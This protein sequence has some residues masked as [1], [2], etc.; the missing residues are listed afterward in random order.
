MMGFDNCAS[1]SLGEDFDQTISD[2]DSNEW[3]YMDRLDESTGSE[4]P[5]VHDSCLSERDD[6]FLQSIQRTFSEDFTL[7]HKINTETTTEN[8]P[9]RTENLQPSQTTAPRKRER[10]TRS[11]SDSSIFYTNSVKA[12]NPVKRLN[13]GALATFHGRAAATVPKNRLPPVASASVSTARVADSEGFTSTEMP[14]SDHSN[15]PQRA[16]SVGAPSIE[17][18][19]CR[20]FFISQLYGL[21]GCFSI[22][23]PVRRYSKRRASTIS[24]MDNQVFVPPPQ[25][26]TFMGAVRNTLRGHGVDFVIWVNESSFLTVLILFLTTY[27]A[28]VCIFAWILVQ[29]DKKTDGRCALDADQIWTTYQ[30]YELA[31]E[32]SWSTFTTV[33]YGQVSP[34]GYENGCY[35]FRV[36]CASF[37]FLGLL[38]NSLSA[39]IF[40][41]KL[42]RYLTRSNIT[43]TS[44]V[45]LRYGRSSSWMSGG[46]YGQFLRRAD[47]RLSL[48]FGSPIRTSGKGT[49][50][51]DLRGCSDCSGSPG[52][53][54]F[55]K[56]TSQFGGQEFG[57]GTMVKDKEDFFPQA[58]STSRKHPHP[59][60]EFR[61]VNEHANYRMREIRNAHVSAMVQLTPDD[62]E[63]M[64]NHASSAG[65][66]LREYVTPAPNR[67]SSPTKVFS[68]KTSSASQSVAS[69]LDDNSGH[70]PDSA[71]LNNIKFLTAVTV[72]EED[73]GIGKQAG[74]EGRVYFPLT[75][76]PS[77]HPYFRRVWYIRHILD[78]RSPMLKPSV[79]N[80]I[81]NGW[82]PSL[83]T[84]TDILSCL[85]DF[86][87]IRMT[88]K[89]NSAVTNS[90][91]FAQKVY[92]KDDLF[93]GWQFSDIFYKRD[94]G[95]WW[96]RLLWQQ[97]D[98][99]VQNMDEN[100]ID[101]CDLV[102]D[103]RLIHDILPQRDGDNEPIEG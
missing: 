94:R 34:S 11:V 97:E 52:S 49:S 56:S 13:D 7:V 45:C 40:F 68:T 23:S 35:P 85:V 53:P 24:V 99:E 101:D 46:E 6:Q 41:S 9:L 58:D 15:S 31:F 27:Y 5:P 81:K 90:M 65:Q 14:S 37:A 32:L 66:L 79:R 51:A 83:C 72:Q 28:L 20:D 69:G 77:S 38:F 10:R 64:M 86:R 80:K 43:F 84:Y 47:S 1:G 103:K 33:G 17:E 22:F 91:V 54:R 48:H 57:H 93:V 4:H 29:T 96:K 88:L 70:R 39:A 89:G 21:T 76:E 61:I 2:K 73:S 74:P 30:Q 95:R 82:D 18:H 50:L 26:L 71:R 62:A 36:L 60:L 75:L 55:S 19:T 100:E 67:N 44:S 59:F 87:I 102:L 16:A 12:R 25:D 78:D 8:I 92:T 3:G 42:E 63:R 98:S